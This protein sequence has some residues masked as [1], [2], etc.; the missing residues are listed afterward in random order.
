ML[1]LGYLVF[2]KCK[3]F[4]HTRT[5][6]HRPKNI[7][8]DLG[9]IFMFSMVLRVQECSLKPKGL[10]LLLE[11]MGIQ[12]GKRQ[13]QDD[14]DWLVERAADITTGKCEQSMVMTCR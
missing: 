12:F 11:T 13:T 6:T 10:T 7:S 1:T 14:P 3:S 5:H 9:H 4:L 2:F 8:S